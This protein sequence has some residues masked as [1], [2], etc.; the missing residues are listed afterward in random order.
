MNLACL[1]FI[2]FVIN[3]CHSEEELETKTFEELLPLLKERGLRQ[4][5]SGWVTRDR[6]RSYGVDPDRIPAN[7]TDSWGINAALR[8]AG[9]DTTNFKGL[10]KKK[11]EKKG[12]DDKDENALGG[13]H[14][15]HG[16]KDMKKDG[17]DMKN[18]GTDMNKDGMNKN[19]DNMD[20]KNGNNMKGNSKKMAKD[21]SDEEED[22]DDEDDKQENIKCSKWDARCL[23]NR[24]RPDIVVQRYQRQKAEEK[25]RREERRKKKMEEDDDD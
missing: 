17:M 16:D 12:D 2:L 8:A 14:K 21:K 25:K 9:A 1:L 15:G 5:T 7:V 3:V 11:S 4:S 19:K 10:F 18:S 6:V 23:R 24:L 22:D 20:M 13:K